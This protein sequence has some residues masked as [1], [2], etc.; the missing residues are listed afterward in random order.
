MSL[1]KNVELHSVSLIHRTIRKHVTC[2]YQS[3]QVHF[4]GEL[5]SPMTSENQGAEEMA[6]PF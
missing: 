4:W 5:S 2:C 3:A 6:M 1:S